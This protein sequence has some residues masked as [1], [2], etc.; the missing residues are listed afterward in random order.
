L[1]PEPKPNDEPPQRLEI[2]EPAF[3]IDMAPIRYLEIV[4]A[5]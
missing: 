3:G 2:I 5:A 1:V 4:E